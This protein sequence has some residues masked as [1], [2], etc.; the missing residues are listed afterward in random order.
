M[1]GFMTQRGDLNES[2]DKLTAEQT[3]ALLWLYY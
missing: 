1:K 2:E 3:V